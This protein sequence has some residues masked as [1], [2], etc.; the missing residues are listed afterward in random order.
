MRQPNRFK[1]CFVCSK[2]KPIEWAHG[3]C[4]RK[5]NLKFYGTYNGVDRFEVPDYISEEQ[6]YNYWSLKYKGD[7]I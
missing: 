3:E 1:R 7:K 2:E 4:W 6:E 5:F